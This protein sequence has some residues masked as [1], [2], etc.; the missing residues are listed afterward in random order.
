M[1]IRS[2]F[3][4]EGTTSLFFLFSYVRTEGETSSDNICS[5]F[6]H[7]VRTMSQEDLVATLSSWHISGSS[8]ITRAGYRDYLQVSEHCWC[9]CRAQ[10]MACRIK[11]HDSDRSYEYRS[12]VITDRPHWRALR[13]S[14]AEE[15][16]WQEDIERCYHRRGVWQTGEGSTYLWVLYQ[17]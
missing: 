1:K 13:A 14:G 11:W 16:I 9:F 17:N 10:W 7:H 3:L 2:S 12:E 5:K 6:F 4:R 15:T 8:H